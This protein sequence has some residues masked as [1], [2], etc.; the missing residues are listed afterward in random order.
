MMLADGV[1]QLKLPSPAASVNTL[2]ALAAL[3]D[4]NVYEFVDVL[5]V[6]APA[7]VMRARSVLLVPKIID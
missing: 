7:L 2:P 6:I 3:V 5:K 4:G 1:A